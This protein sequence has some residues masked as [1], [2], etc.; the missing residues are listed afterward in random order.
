MNTEPYYTGVAEDGLGG[1]LR[2][3]CALL[4]PRG[5]RRLHRQGILAIGQNITFATTKYH[6]PMAITLFDQ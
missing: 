2:I 1:H 5:H 3:G 6:N 4:D